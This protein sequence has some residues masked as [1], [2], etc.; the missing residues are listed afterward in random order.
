MS[1]KL[2]TSMPE[3]VEAL[4]ERRDTLDISNETIDAIAGFPERYTSKL[5]APRAP[6]NL[7]YNSLGQ[8]LGALGVALQ[9]V[10]DFEQAAKV[11]G[12]WSKRKPQGP[13]YKSPLCVVGQEQS[14]QAALTFKNAEAA[15][16]QHA[17]G[18]GTSPARIESSHRGGGGEGSPEA[19][20]L[21][22]AALGRGSGEEP[23]GSGDDGS[24]LR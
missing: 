23:R 9:V 12:R 10:E 7:S 20:R 22:A 11:R 24:G 4:R 13:R 6:R 15:N 1:G 14:P 17:H 5:L 19:V 8:I 21:D 16:G 18:G 2:I 3:L